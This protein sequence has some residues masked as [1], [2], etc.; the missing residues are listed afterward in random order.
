MLILSSMAIFPHN[1]KWWTAPKANWHISFDNFKVLIISTIINFV[2]KV[3]ILSSMTT[4]PH[5][6]RSLVFVNGSECRNCLNSRFCEKVYVTFS[7]LLK[8]AQSL[9]IEYYYVWSH[10]SL[11]LI[12]EWYTK[13]FQLCHIPIFLGAEMNFVVHVIPW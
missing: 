2:W 12:Y 8:I 10:W 3:L 7:R 1:V 11:S 9:E 13:F 6:W 5:M 4:F